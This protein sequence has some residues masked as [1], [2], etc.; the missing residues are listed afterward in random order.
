VQLASDIIV[1]VVV[2]EA[3]AVIH[4]SPGHIPLAKRFC[5]SHEDELA[6]SEVPHVVGPT[7]AQVV[8]EVWKRDLDLSPSHILR[9]CSSHEDQLAGS[10]VPHVVG[11]ASAQAVDEVWKRDLDLSPSHI[12]PRK[13][14]H[15]SHEDQLAR[16]KVSQPEV[17]ST[18]PEEP[19]A[20]DLLLSEGMQIDVPLQDSQGQSAEVVP[21]PPRPCFELLQS[22]Q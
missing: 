8:D 5:S 9:L 6:E 7:P 19:R 2:E 13:R 15:S 16:P 11:S 4:L 17:S 14:L 22:K 10:E 3:Q 21:A 1:K 12:T 20:T 18:I